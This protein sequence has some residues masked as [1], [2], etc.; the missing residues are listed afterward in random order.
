MIQRDEKEAKNLRLALELYAAGEELKRQSL[1]REHPD[2]TAD[3]I[4]VMLVD[5]LRDRP[6][7]P[8]GDSPG[9]RVT[10]EEFRDR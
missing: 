1:K 6:G 7:A 9:R 2:S 3:E 10:L 4:E 8:D 5:W